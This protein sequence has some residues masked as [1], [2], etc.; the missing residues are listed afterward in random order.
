[1]PNRIVTFELDSWDYSAWQRR[2]SAHLTSPSAR[3]TIHEIYAKL[4]EKYVPYKTG[5]L[6][7]N[8]YVDDEQIV[9]GYSGRSA[10]YAIFP[11]H[12][13]RKGKRLNYTTTVH[14][15][16][17]SHW[18]QAVLKHDMNAFKWRVTHALKK[19]AEEEGW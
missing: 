14:P 19:L 13:V 9:W 11:Y 4:T 16:A 18:D 6:N 17:R 7:D 12:G 8:V 1:M 10:E 2:F 5:D 15:L 3:W